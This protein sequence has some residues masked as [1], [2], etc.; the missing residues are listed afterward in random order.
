M[1]SGKYFVTKSGSG[2]LKVMELRYERGEPSGNE[3][4]V[5]YAHN[6]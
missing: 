2:A 4:E 3:N 5:I 6:A 1:K